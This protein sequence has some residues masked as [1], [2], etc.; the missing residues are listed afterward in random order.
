MVG[1]HD[2]S[3][4]ALERSWIEVA[5]GPEGSW[6]RLESV[7]SREPFGYVSVSNTAAP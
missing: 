3:W 5:G 4:R 1:S 2:L 6:G 7:R